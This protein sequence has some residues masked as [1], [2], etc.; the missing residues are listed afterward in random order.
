VLGKPPG[1]E[2]AGAAE[3]R[4][5][6]PAA[7]P[8]QCRD[9]GDVAIFA[10]P[11][12]PN[13]QQAARVIVTSERDPGPADLFLFDAK[14]NRITP[15]NVVRLAG[16]PPWS[17]IA[18]LD[19]PAAGALTA[20]LGDGSRVE[21]CSRISIAAHAPS[22]AGSASLT[23]PVWPNDRAWGRATENLYATFVQRLFDFPP[24]QDLTWPNLHVLLRDPTHN[25]LFDHLQR[26]EEAK[27]ALQPDCAD[28]PYVLRAYFAWKMHLPFAYHFCS[29]G[30]ATHAPKCD[31]RFVTNTV[32]RD[33][34]DTKKIDLDAE[35]SSAPIAAAPAKP[36]D[37]VTAFKKFWA[38]HVSRAVH[39]AS[40]RTVPDDDATDYYP[41]A[42]RRDALAPGTVYIDPFGHVMIVS[43]WVPQAATSYGLLLA[44][45]AQPDATVGRKRFWRGNF[46]FATDT[47]VAGAGF[48][49]F[50]PVR[51]DDAT[52]QLTLLDN[53]ALARS[54]VFSPFSLQQYEGTVD[55][56]FDTVEALV[57]PRPLEASAALTSLVD[58]L[59]SQAKLRL[60]SVKNG[61]DFFV[62]HPTQ[63]IPFPDGADIFLTSGPWEDFATPARD[64][65]LLIAIDTVLGFTDTVRRTPKRFSL[66]AGPALDATIARLQKELEAALRAR[67]F[68]YPRSDGSL[69]TLTLR[70]LVDRKLALEVAYD[71]ND[72][73]ELRWGAP[74]GS[75]EMATCKRHAPADHRKKLET[76]R[77][78]FHERKRPAR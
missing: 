46:L 32:T 20:V 45:D 33:L 53:K 11:R 49:S 44:A 4:P 56:F 71:P 65:R 17:V 28:L 37:D 77:Q 24:D 47:K 50:R 76:A 60:V 57:N 48:K 38:Q 22:A 72:C 55:T 31:P 41:V 23:A 2:L 42:L 30:N 6:A 52:H 40:G 59:Y 75:P 61:E 36:L 35:V 13:A 58:S 67:T 3:L 51:V 8:K 25:I 14:G 26:D 5:A 70:D 16:G 39:A 21:A 74:A 54:R 78:W 10:S 73:P 9:S 15:T 18:T 63:V 62:Q 7:P 27:L 34:L 64:F 12:V 1:V 68:Q 43:G 69:Q 66:E 19:K 29:R